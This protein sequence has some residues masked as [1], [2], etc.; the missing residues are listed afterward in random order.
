MELSD[1]YRV[2]QSILYDI[3]NSPRGMSTGEIVAKYGISRRVVPKYINIFEDS[4]IPI[5]VVDK[6]YYIDES[7]RSAFTLTPE[8]SELLALSLQRSL[9]LHQSNRRTIRSL[10]HKLGRKMTENVAAAL[11]SQ[12]VGEN[13]ESPSERWFSTLAEAKRLL[14]EVVVEYHPLN[15][16]EPTRWQIRPHQFVA[17]PFSD[18]LYVLCDATKDG[19]NYVPLSLKFDRILNVRRTDVHFDIVARAKFASSKGHAWGVWSS[20]R[21]PTRVVLRF[22]ARHYDRLLE[23][24]WHPTQTISVDNSGDVRFS[25]I[26]SEPLEM[27]P[28]IRSWGSGVVVLEPD[29]L[30]QRIINSLI[31][32]MHTYGLAADTVSSQSEMHIAMLWA[33]YDPQTGAYHPLICHAL[34]AA[35][36]AWVMWNQGLSVH[37]RE[38]LKDI[39]DIDEASAQNL[40]SFFVSLHDIGKATP[41][42]QQKAKPVYEQLLAVGIPDE[43]NYDVAHGASSAI[44]LLRLL[45]ERGIRKEAAGAISSA[46]GGH[47]GAWIND[48]E[49]RKADGVGSAPEWRQLQSELFEILSNV[50]RIDEIRIPN[51]G[52][53]LNQFAVF[54][55]GF[56][57]VCDW[58][59][60]HEEYFP[61]QQKLSDPLRY[62]EYAV[63]L[64][65]TALEEIGWQAWKPSSTKGDFIETFAFEPND[66]QRAAIEILEHLAAPPRLIL[67]EYM[68]GGGKTELAL[69]I[70]D[71]LMNLHALSGA[72]IAMPTQATSNQMYE[73]VSRFLQARYP[74]QHINLQLAHAQSDMH[75]L[76]QQFQQRG[77]RE[78][79][80]GGITAERWFQNRKRT[81]L[82]P[83]AVG[84]VDQAMM[85]VLQVQHHFVRQFAL[86]HKVVIFDEV[87]SYD[88]YMNEIIARLIQWL[89]GLQSPLFL[90]SATLPENARMRLLQQANALETATISD[91]QYPR[92]TIVAN[93]G[94][95]QTHALPK[96][97]SRTLY[98]HQIDTD[99]EW[100]IRDVTAAYRQ[101]GCIAIICNTV[102]EA[103]GIARLL[104]ESPAISPEDVTLFH[105]RFPSAWRGQIEQGV[106]SRFG[107]DGQ[108]PQRAILVATQIIEQSLD[109]D[110]D[111]I[112]TNTAPIDLLIQRAGRLHR[113]TRIRPE[114][115]SQPTLVVRTPEFNGEVPDFGVDQ[116]VYQRYILLKT[117][118]VLQGRTTLRLPDELDDVMDF[119]YS[120][121]HHVDGISDA[122]AKALK[123]AY[124]DMT[125][126]DSGS[127]F[128]GI[129]HLIAEP[130]DEMLIG[131]FSERLPD[132]DD[133]NITTRDIRPG[134]DIICMSLDPN[135]GLPHPVDRKPSKDEV[136]EYLQFRIVVQDTELV[137]AL[138]ALPLNP[139]WDRIGGL[140]Y[141]RAVIFGDGEFP[142]PGTEHR[143][144][145]S[146]LYGLEYVKKEFV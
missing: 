107:K 20:S 1:I 22:D 72:Y 45:K 133:H 28:W 118:L 136:R 58:I 6:R 3:A 62:F 86:S 124:D 73:R 48:V 84:T 71:I 77:E 59:G 10:S 126:S 39:L 80:E 47:H 68:T 92:L 41:N 100:L 130:G 37:Q 23:S 137:R 67:V 17:N 122:F 65:Q 89:S 129:Q 120:D 132:D 88:T 101:G 145:L 106:L 11:I 33:K 46:I 134:V 140:R 114:H 42:F 142:I 131:S 8:E 32:Q 127:R 98:V 104:R 40:L 13:Y 2:M 57:S 15:R 123:T 85:S 110:F 105:A 64:A 144:R 76:Y 109:L 96:P 74:D 63:K 115:L 66:F 81:L 34:D 135:S 44:V 111:L 21:E 121:D 116:A 112:V 97:P 102:N 108:R 139:Y 25:V 60:S 75:P 53:A 55:S 27:I 4:G 125:L 90:L 35:A 91:V 43:R 83:Y 103:I 9:I 113:H 30:R 61:Y 93:D 128:R 82:A 12:V 56:V 51:D 24:R 16:P 94:N 138:K 95:V 78:G 5:Y 143:L 119:V 117:W 52:T 38:W 54:L 19:T 14:L 26:V 7:Y 18:G 50:L 146:P 36:V 31:R 29:S 79:N 70:A 141:A 69:H 99:S 87:H 49:M